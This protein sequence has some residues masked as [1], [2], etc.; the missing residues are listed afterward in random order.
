MYCGEENSHNDVGAS[1]SIK[2]QREKDKRE[3]GKE[4]DGTSFSL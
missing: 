2:E 1:G 3:E 4:G